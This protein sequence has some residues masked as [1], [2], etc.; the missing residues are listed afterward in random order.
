MERIEVRDV[1][2]FAKSNLTKLPTF[3]KPRALCYYSICTCFSLNKELL[4]R[5][6][7]GGRVARNGTRHTYGS[8]GINWLCRRT[9]LCIPWAQNNQVGVADWFSFCLDNQ[10]Q[11]ISLHWNGSKPHQNVEQCQ[12][13]SQYLVMDSDH[14]QRDAYRSSCTR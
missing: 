10:N 1:L 9:R 12:K 4:G 8:L 2:Q 6:V 14:N 5:G 3:Q 11:L 13:A 7:L